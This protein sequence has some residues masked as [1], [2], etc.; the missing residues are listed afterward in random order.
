MIWN[1]DIET[2]PR[3]ALRALQAERL[4][5]TVARARAR[6]PFYRTA[7]DAPGARDGDVDLTRLGELPFTRKQGLRDHYPFGLFAAPREDVVR[8]H[9]SSGTRGK[10]TV[11]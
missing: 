3:A 8:I 4:R 11:V 1:R 6:V 5:A 10:P 2:A 9:A 7:L